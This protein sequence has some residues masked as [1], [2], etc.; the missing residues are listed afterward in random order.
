[1]NNESWQGWLQ[2]WSRPWRRVLSQLAN[3][4]AETWRFQDPLYGP[5]EHTLAWPGPRWLS[6]NPRF[7]LPFFHICTLFTQYFFFSGVRFKLTKDRLKKRKTKDKKNKK[8]KHLLPSQANMGP[9]PI[10]EIWGQIDVTT[11]DRLSTVYVNG[12][13]ITIWPYRFIKVITH[14]QARLQV[15]M[16]ASTW[17]NSPMF[18]IMPIQVG[19]VVV[20]VD[21]YAVSVCVRVCQP[22]S[23]MWSHSVEGEYHGLDRPQLWPRL[24]CPT[25]TWSCITCSHNTWYVNDMQIICMFCEKPFVYSNKI[26]Q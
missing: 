5:A 3:K 21:R 24:V 19:N 8:Q 22:L 17:Q 25:E 2:L 12:D 13:V 10:G 16:C 23:P 20:S 14:S 18:Q 15:L 1:M 9:T 6:F 11:K 26:S 7:C 4:H